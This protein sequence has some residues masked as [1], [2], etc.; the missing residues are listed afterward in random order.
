[1]QDYIVFLEGNRTDTKLSGESQLFRS[2]WTALPNTTVSFCECGGNTAMPF[3]LLK[4]LS[5]KNYDAV[6]LNYDTI[7]A[8]LTPEC[9][10]IFKSIQDYC[11]SLSVP[12]YI[13][14]YPSFEALLLHSEVV[15]DLIKHMGSSFCGLLQ[16]TRDSFIAFLRYGNYSA[17][18]SYR[19]PVPKF[20]SIWLTDTNAEKRVHSLVSQIT[21]KF[22]KFWHCSKG[23]VG[24]CWIALCSTIQ[25]LKYACIKQSFNG[26]FGTCICECEKVSA[27][28]ASL[29]AASIRDLYVPFNDAARKVYL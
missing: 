3:K 21:F 13:L 19:T 15:V 14:Q 1:M 5:K 23:N 18:C 11:Q 2:L 22:H 20:N 24:D 12:C 7:N 9:S 27:F 6:Y 4:E 28:L 29:S 25:S 17:L 8:H 10:A 26:H 16:S